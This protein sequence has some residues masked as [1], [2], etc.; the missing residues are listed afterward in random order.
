[1]SRLST[2]ALGGSSRVQG[3][4]VARIALRNPDL[5]LLAIA[6]PVFL[7]G[8][9]PI[10]GWAVATAAWLVGRG[11]K[12]LADRR[13]ARALAE[14]DRRTA[15]GLEAASTLARVWILALAVLLVGLAEREAGLAAAVLAAA[16][17]TVYLIGRMI[18]HLAE[19]AG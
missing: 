6:L 17:V 2:L 8:G 16:V 11:V 9:L 4:G 19:D 13:G 7:L 5:I 18:G 12:L 14:G 15:L 3:A 1:M 10:A